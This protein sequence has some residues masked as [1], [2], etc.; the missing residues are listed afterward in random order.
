MTGCRAVQSTVSGYIWKNMKPFL[1]GK[2]SFDKCY[3]RLYSELELY[4]GE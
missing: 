1:M 4:A 3:D 2:Q